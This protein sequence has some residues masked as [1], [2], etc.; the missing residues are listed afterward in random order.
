MYGKNSHIS[1]KREVL[2][3]KTIALAFYDLR[4]NSNIVLD[5]L[6]QRIYFSSNLN[7]FKTI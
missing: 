4:F 1:L 5:K 6:T 2:I 7:A 3:K